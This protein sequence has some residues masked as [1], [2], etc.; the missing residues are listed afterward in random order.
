MKGLHHVGFTVRDLDASIRFYYDVLGLPFKNEPSPWFEDESL[1]KAVGVPG[2]ALRQVSLA[3]GDTTLEVLEFKS[4]PSATTEPLA[5][6]SI[7][8][9]HIAFLVDDIY[10][11]KAE[12]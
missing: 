1:G 5:S 9:S 6:N 12:L 10:A 11:K 8:A 2:A 4:L 3:A 7:G